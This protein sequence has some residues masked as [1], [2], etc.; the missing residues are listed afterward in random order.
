MVSEDL[1][2]VLVNGHQDGI[3]L[4]SFK[5]GENPNAIFFE[6]NEAACKLSG[7]TR[8]ELL[9]LTPLDLTPSR[10]RLDD[11]SLIERCRT[12]QTLQ[13]IDEL[14]R[15]DGAK[16]PVEIA[17]RYFVFEDQVIGLSIVKDGTE[18]ACEALLL[19]MAKQVLNREPADQLLRMM[20][21]RLVEIYDLVQAV[22]GLKQP[23]G[24]LKMLGWG[25]Y[26]TI[27]ERFIPGRWDEDS[28]QLP[29]IGKVLL[30]G[31]PLIGQTKADLLP[32]HIQALSRLGEGIERFN[33]FA[34]LP[35]VAGGSVIGGLTLASRHEH[36]WGERLVE[37]LRH[38]ANQAAIAIMA[39]EYRQR[40][41]LLHA[42]LHAAAN[43]VLICDACGAVQWVN[44]AFTKLTGYEPEEVMG[45]T[46]RFLYPS[47]QGQDVY[48]QLWETVATG[49]AW[50]GEMVNRRKD[51]SLY[52]VETT[53][54]P[55]E[56]ELGE[57]VNYISI[58]QDITEKLKAIEESIAAK[59]VRTRAEKLFSLGTLAAGISH[60]INQ[61]L[62]SIKMISS[63]IVY[64]HKQGRKREVDEIIANVEEVSR[65]ADRIAGIINHLRSYF[66]KDETKVEILDVNVAAAQAI[67]VVGKQLASHGILLETQLGEAPLSIRANLISLEEIVINL[68][69]NAMQALDTTT[70]REKRI[71][72]RTVRQDEDVVLSVSDNGP[73][74]DAAIGDKI[75]EPFYSTKQGEENLGLGLAIVHSLVT[76]SNGSIRYESDGKTG[77]AFFV[78]LPAVETRG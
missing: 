37:R 25:Q 15:K 11:A 63:G 58:R 32:G 47:R 71:V 19:D 3:F 66:R 43:A 61:P 16:I 18:R 35:L 22:V 21:S 59:E 72:L 50:Q 62:N 42:G 46:P 48:Q 1:Y 44:P 78:R 45:K 75:F 76:A 31:Q 64:A 73:G 29:A 38:F 40:S 68:L 56:N 10:H 55:V 13:F 34:T 74:I 67:S 60:E 26:S 57:I 12:E 24:S 27:A 20:C 51:G 33:S 8:E 30:S 5:E 49:K 36:F 77:T 39:S 69:V 4:R 41:N 53:I 6:V 7:Y 14:V 65:Q 2:R 9:R 28:D 54:T 52:T 23:D 70:S 17:N